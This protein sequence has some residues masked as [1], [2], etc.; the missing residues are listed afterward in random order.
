MRS[1]LMKNDMIQILG[2]TPIDE[3]PHCGSS[4]FC[5][6]FCETDKLTIPCQKPDIKDMIEVCVSVS[7]N[8][9]KIICTPQGKKLIIDGVKHVKL[10][11]S[12]Y[13]SC[14]SVHCA[15]FDIPFCEF[16][17]LRHP[18][19]KVV[20]IN[21][22]I[23]HICVHSI[24]CRDVILSVIVLLCPVF[25]KH[26]HYIDPCSED[27]H[28]CEDDC[29]HD[30]HECEDDCNDDNCECEDDCSCHEE[31]HNNCRKFPEESSCHE[32]HHKQYKIKDRENMEEKY[33]FS[34]CN[35]SY[36]YCDED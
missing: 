23:E 35:T 13:K 21:T 17:L 15:H 32:E 26:C 36:Y 3:F 11:Y 1:D 25:K 14:Q 10:M 24:N 30:N 34:N 31:H 5:K 8:G 16:I 4:Q 7:I 22:A 18:F 20:C 28:G 9:F 12:A 27:N 19:E 29:H 2:V 33:D 6:E